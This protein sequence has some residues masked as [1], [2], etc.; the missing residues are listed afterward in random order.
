MLVATPLAL[1]RDA[2]AVP[3]LTVYAASSRICHQRPERSFHIAG[4]KLP[5]CARCFGL[6]AA[7]ALG[8]VIAWRSGRAPDR[9]ARLALL[10]SAIPTA[11]TWLLEFAGL[12][13]FSNLTRA[14][15]A[16]PVGAVTGWLLVQML[17]YDSFLNGEI[18]HRGS[19][20][21]SG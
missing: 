18:D 20:V 16:L 19:R 21:R 6:Y 12:A 5:V 10:V 2:L 8:S 9:R 3:A 7:A 17:R 15:A 14:V 1:T 11:A 4:F 13:A